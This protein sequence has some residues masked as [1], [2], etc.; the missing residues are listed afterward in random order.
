MS[1]FLILIAAVIGIGGFWFVGGYNS[2][3]KLK[4]LVD[5]AWSGIDVQLKR[6]YDLIPNLVETVKGYQVHEKEVFEN[7]ARMRSVSMNAGS[8]DAKIEAEAGLSGALKTLFAVAENYP[9]LKANSN[10]Q[11]LQDDLGKIEEEL[12]LAR[13]YYNGTARK[14]NVRVGQMP[15]NIIARM[16]GF[17]KAPF[18]ELSSQEE[19]QAPKVTF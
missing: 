11:S 3:V 5:E 6:R 13:R 9:E 14:Y 7:V 4:A 12:Q 1:M 17:D 18:F 16:S 15:T 19:K 8:V 10:F 2:L